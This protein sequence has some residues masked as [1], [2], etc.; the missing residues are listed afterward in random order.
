[1]IKQKIGRLKNDPFRDAFKA[2]NSMICFEVIINGEKVC[3]AGANERGGLFALFSYVRRV[4]EENEEEPSNKPYFKV[5]AH[6]I[7]V[8][9]EWTGGILEIG[10][11]VTIRVLEA[12]EFDPPVREYRDD[13]EE[14]ARRSRDYYEE[15]KRKF[16]GA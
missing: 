7:G 11:E 15:L 13:P 2:A 9:S 12:N 1:M 3:T 10:D 6:N 16:E 14:Q 5:S 8:R 4:A